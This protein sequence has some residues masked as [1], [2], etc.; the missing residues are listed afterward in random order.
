VRAARFGIAGAI[1]LVEATLAFALVA[2]SDRN[3]EPWLTAIP[4]LTAGVT[5]V[6]AGLVALWRR[7][8]NATGMWLAATGYLWFLASLTE[9]KDP[10]MWT[11]GFILGNLGLVC[12]AAL[13]LAYPDGV[14]C[15]RD[16]FL[17][18]AGAVAAIGGN[19]L[20]ALLDE[21]PATQCD[22]CPRSAIALT[23]SDLAT[24]VVVSVG[25][26][27]IVA[28][29]ITIVVILIGRWRTASATRRR[30]LRPVYV[31]CSV[32]VVLLLLSVATD[33]MASRTYSINWL[34]FLVWF[35]I[36]PMT[37]L[38]GV[39]RTRFDRASAARMLVSLD[40]G[41]PLRDVL[42]EALHDPSL[43]IVFWNDRRGWIDELGREVPTPEA[44]ELRS[45]TMVDRGG[46]RTAALLHDPVLDSEPDLVRLIATGASLPL[47]NVRLQADLRAQFLFLET[48]TNTAPSL[49]V[50][51]DTDGRILNQNRA[52][53]EA[54]GYPVEE[55]LRGQYFWDV[56]IEDSDRD[57]MQQRFHA[58]A[59]DYPGAQYE[60]AFTNE[61]GEDRVIEWRSAPVADATGRV[62]TIVLGGIDITE[63][64]QRE[65]QLQRERDITATLMQAIP[66]LI[67]VVDNDG[68]IVDSGIDENRA[69]VNNA[70]RAALGWPDEALVRTSVLEFI[71]P[72]DAY[73]ASM[74]IAG[75]ANGVTMPERESRWLRAD[76]GHLHIA[77]TAT[78]I[79]D[80]TGR[81]ASLVLLSGVDVTERKA[82]EAEIRASRTRIIEAAGEARQKLERNLHDGAQQR[83]VSL[84]VSL[85]LA[86]SLL[87]SDPDGAR[88]VLSGSREE[89]AAALEE[90]RELA[91]GIHPAVLTDQGLAAAIEALALRTPVPIEID[92]PNERLP[93]TV[94]AAAYY[95]V[96]EALTNVVKYAGA[97]RVAVTVEAD[98]DWATVTVAD[99]GIGGADPSRG[100]G[101]AGLRD[102]IEALDGTFSVVSTPEGGTRITAEM[103]LQV[104]DAVEVDS[105]S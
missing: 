104:T 13:I 40:E 65:L 3:S 73:V 82:H 94:E 96:S 93:A 31:S 75:A 78:A 17:V 24:K 11:S 1:A 6:A 70:V 71:D 50:V 68:T 102:R 86:E 23:S 69:G 9:A 49:L 72:G 91:R 25:S 60:N 26:L 61:R 57:A 101:L 16:R 20:I 84:S 77:W 38:A 19:L 54:S 42:A 28:L 81:K 41:V 79:D 12:F 58:L 39:L 48:V 74:M 55:N 10:V 8:E 4:A 52:T 18:A 29:L 63:R 30:T 2:A 98:D 90:L 105:A 95:V 44:T 47:E 7:P 66:S 67:I 27:I 62:T 97:T 32:T 56:F 59:P 100:T 89:L 36:V 85:R 33:Q 53:L 92:L 103:P 64:N 43:E 46:H 22:D 99:D 15:R 83:L 88:M 51:I 45:V 5:F 34:L 14:L 80:V 35:A 87:D 21:T 76:G 37:F